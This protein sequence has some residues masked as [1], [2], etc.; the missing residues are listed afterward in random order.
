[1]A[2]SAFGRNIK[3]LRESKGL[4]QEDLSKAIG[5][6]TVSISNWERGASSQPKE[7]A[8]I[9]KI[10]DFF[11]VTDEDLFGYNDGYYAKMY[12]LTER[13]PGSE[14]VNDEPR[15]VYASM[16]GLIHAGDAD[17]P[18]IIYDK[19]PI[20]YEVWEHHKHGF[21]LEVIGDCMDKVYPPGCHVFVDPKTEPN[22]GSIV[23]A[24]IDGGDYVMRRLRKGANTIMLSPDSH[25]KD[26]D[27]IVLQGEHELSIAGVVV[28]FQSCHELE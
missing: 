23:V 15:K 21:F 8:V 22:D 25:N 5:V 17:E 27:D 28:W 24:S 18:V 4:R 11:G 19:V 26:W 3:A 16:Y 2:R 12:G 13:P 14:A 1:M 20:P 6:T 9:A 10:K 7:Q